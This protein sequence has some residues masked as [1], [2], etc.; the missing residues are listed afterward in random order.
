MLE[1]I[2]AKKL[3]V[4]GGIL[5]AGVLFLYILGTSHKEG[6][7]LKVLSDKVDLQIK[8]FHYTEVGNPDLTW[9][10]SA[11]TA[12]YTK[13]D[14]VTLFENV[15]IRL[16]FSNG[17]VYVITGKNGSMHTDTK[18][19]EIK[20]DVVALSDGGAR[21]E[22]AT[23]HYTDNGGDGMIHTKD[24]VKMTRPGADVR[25]TGMNLSLK[26]KE[27]TLLSGVIATIER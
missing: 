25:G 7:A 12:T 21:F 16:L 17:E 3:F 23:L 1:K 5:L 24:A 20:G 10:I 13:K 8:D 15:E 14:D 26:S 2:S 4:G 11:D 6:S 19:M 18:D 27:I 9:E 22:T